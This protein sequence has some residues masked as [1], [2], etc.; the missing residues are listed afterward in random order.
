MSDNKLSK[1]IKDAISQ[2][3]PEMVAKEMKDFVSKAEAAFELVEVQKKQIENQ[4]ETIGKLSKTID[5]LE[6]L[7]IEKEALEEGHRLLQESKKELEIDRR[8]FDAVLVAHQENANNIYTLVHLLCSTPEE[9]A[10]SF[11]FSLNGSGNVPMKDSGGYFSTQYMSA[12]LDGSINKQE[13]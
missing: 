7:K 11:N 10:K 12:S 9:K 1:N 2:S 13:L 8:V 6:N 3:L 5:E 4:N